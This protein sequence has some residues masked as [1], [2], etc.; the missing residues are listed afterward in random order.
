MCSCIFSVN[1]VVIRE[2]KSSKGRFKRKRKCNVIH[3][4]WHEDIFNLQKKLKKIKK[5]KIRVKLYLVQ[6]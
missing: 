3:N 1:L 5:V 6:Y 2:I 4:S